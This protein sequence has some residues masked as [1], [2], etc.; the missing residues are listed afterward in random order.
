MDT[1]NPAA[2]VNAE[3]L[4]RY[5]GRRVRCVV[6]VVRAEGNSAFAGLTSDSMHISIKQ[7]SP[8]SSLSQFVEV[9]G[10]VDSDRSLRAEICTNFGDNFD[11]ASFN[12]LVQMANSDYQPL[13]M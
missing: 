9:I 2:L 3:L 5:V 8:I 12:Q 6:K 1:S 7:A 11:M 10:V 13:F 4:K